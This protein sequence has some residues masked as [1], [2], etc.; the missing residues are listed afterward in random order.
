MYKNVGPA[1][2]ESTRHWINGHPTPLVSP[3]S[4]YPQYQQQWSSWG[5]GALGDVVVEVESED[6]T[7]G[8][9]ES[10]DHVT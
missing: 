2:H 6:G 10:V 1:G 5:V 7:T 3:M 8:V 9:G 4:G